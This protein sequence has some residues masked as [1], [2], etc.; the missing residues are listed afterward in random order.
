MDINKTV[1]ANKLAR[2]LVKYGLVS[3]M[4][5]GMSK[6]TTMVKEGFDSVPDDAS[7]QISV[8]QPASSQQTGSYQPSEVSDQPNDTKIFE[9]KLNW[10]V[11]PFSSSPEMFSRLL[12]W[13]PIPI[14]K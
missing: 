6:A 10:S 5:E 9:R 14:Y 7:E 13:A 4:D 8:S 1:Q 2:E 11:T 3:S 12:F